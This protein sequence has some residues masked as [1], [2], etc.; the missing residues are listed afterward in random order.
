MWPSISSRNS[1]RWRSTQNGSDE[2]ERDALVG[3]VRD[4]SGAAD[5]V[6]GRGRI[7]DV[8]LEVRD[9]RARDERLVDVGLVE[10]RARAEER[11]HR[12]L[13]RRA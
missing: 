8:A 9:R 10:L 4:R 7:P 2:R 12:A 5:R 11:A 13:A 6:L 3:A 1:A